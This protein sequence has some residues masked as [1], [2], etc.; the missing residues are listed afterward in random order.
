VEILVRLI[1]LP[2]ELDDRELNMRTKSRSWS[3][4]PY[5]EKVD[6]DYQKLDYFDEDGIE[7][8]A[9]AVSYYA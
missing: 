6:A 4:L 1:L 7:K 2:A 3:V 8:G 9:S 5:P